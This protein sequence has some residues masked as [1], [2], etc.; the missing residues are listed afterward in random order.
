MRIF[1]ADGKEAAQCGNGLRCLVDFIRQSKRISSPLAIETEERVV[2]CSWEGDQIT[3]DLGAPQWLFKHT[4]DSYLLQVI[5]T[6]VPHAVAF[7]E[8]LE[9]PDFKSIASKLRHN[10]IFSPEGTNV[11]FA[12]LQGDK[13]YTR[14]YERGVE[15]ETLACGTGAAAVA[16]AAI[17]EYKLKSPICIIPA[18]QEELFVEVDSKTVRLRGRA[19]FV[20]HGVVSYNSSNSL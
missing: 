16:V 5:N 19:T 7:V 13:I 3:V 6:G 8:N 17:K 15:D 14:T 10:T 2:A 9:I 11:N 1:N 18:S 4:V 20:F 12:W